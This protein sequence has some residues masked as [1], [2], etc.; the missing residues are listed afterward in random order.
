MSKPKVL[1]LRTAGT[2]CDLETSFAFELSGAKV[3]LAH[4]NKLID[5]E[6]KLDH[7]EILAIPGGFSYGDDIASGKIL[8]NEIKYKL[9]EK[10]YKF[11]SSGKPVIGICNGFQ[12]LVK[13]GI[14]PK[15]NLVLDDDLKKDP[16]LGFKQSVTLTYN[17]SDK[18]ESRWIYLKIDQNAKIKIQ[19]FW[20]KGLPEIIPLPVAHG[21]G[22]FVAKDSKVLAEIEKNSQVAFRYSD[23]NGALAA[24]PLNPNGAINN[25]AGIFNDKGNI[26]GLMPHPERY[27]FKWQHPNRESVQIAKCK[28]QNKD[29]KETADSECGWG[30]QIFK[31]AVEQVK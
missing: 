28:M 16:S 19:N 14:L 21:E 2:N 17:D 10:L 7:Y 29:K 8:A 25:I 13:M 18:F 20:L 30:L 24:Y 12:V 11:A 22:K 26:L 31:N 15:L 1:V 23:K 6:V 5:N 4:V 3:E 9:G 27:I